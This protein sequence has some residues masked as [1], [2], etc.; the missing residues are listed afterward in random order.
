MKHGLV[1]SGGH[2][3][4][5]GASFA[6]VTHLIQSLTAIVTVSYL[7][8]MQTGRAWRELNL[9][10]WAMICGSVLVHMG[11][12]RFAGR[13]VSLFR[14]LGTSC[15][16]LSLQKTVMRMPNVRHSARPYAKFQ[17]CTKDCPAI[18]PSKP[19]ARARQS[20]SHIVP[21]ISL[22]VLL[23]VLQGRTPLV[24][25]QGSIVINVSILSSRPFR[26]NVS[27]VG[28]CPSAADLR[29]GGTSSQQ[30]VQASPRAPR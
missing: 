3:S 24:R 19:F 6:S 4:R 10:V 29:L 7:P 13:P 17:T 12:H 1:K 25:Q 23:S 22:F 8:L 15:S 16:V 28:N 5:Y 14:N 18:K 2:K 9:N 11:L 30:T 27:M 26:A 20:C 21:V